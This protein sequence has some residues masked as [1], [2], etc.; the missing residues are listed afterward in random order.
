MTKKILITGGTGFIGSNIAKS[1]I[2]DGHKVIIFDN[3]YRGS[4]NNLKIIKKKFKF[5][6]GDI[7]N[8]SDLM[9]AAKDI[10]VIIHLAYING[11][12]YFYTHPELILEVAIKGILNIF[13][14]CKKKKN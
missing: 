1:L 3:N 12:K 9:K 14:V 2:N 6:K 11:T 8:K 4:I 7:R 5:I 13:E 10:N